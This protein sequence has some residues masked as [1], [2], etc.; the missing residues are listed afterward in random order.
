[1]LSVSTRAALALAGWLVLGPPAA[2]LALPVGAG[3]ATNVGRQFDASTLTHL[4]G[5]ITRIERVS[6]GLRAAGVHL[7]LAVK[8]QPVTVVLGPS[9]YID[10][11][12]LKLNPGD[13]VQ[14]TGSQI[15]Q[16]GRTV[17]VA[18]EVHKGGSTMQ[19]RSPGGVPLWAGGRW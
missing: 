18:T 2:A 17:I 8:G 12:T 7:V 4:T 13:V 11:Q 3:P 16:N 9:W 6:H 1:M 19:L 10:Q 14:V 5:S 15:R